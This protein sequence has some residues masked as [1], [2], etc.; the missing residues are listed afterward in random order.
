MNAQ[1]LHVR[2]GE[3]LA[4]SLARAAQTMRDIEQG[5][6]PDPSFDLG[7]ENVAQLFAVFTPKRWELLAV[8]REHGP[9]SIFALARLLRRDYK[10]VH[11]DV[12]ALLEWTVIDRNDQNL[13]YAPFADIS[14][15]VH[16]PQK[17]AA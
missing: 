14:V 7:F 4:R 6:Q 16:L 3:D 1:T 11:A 8:L 10:N 9:L 12:M 5:Q 15:D 2:V 17:Q 13:V